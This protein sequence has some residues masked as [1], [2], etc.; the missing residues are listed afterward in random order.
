[1]EP[2]NFWL[3]ANVFSEYAGTATSYNMYHHNMYI[4]TK[5][6]TATCADFFWTLCLTYDDN[7]FST[8]FMIKRYFKDC[9]KYFV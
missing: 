7:V 9:D 6:L 1:M 5:K 2:A 3:E 8:M 4:R